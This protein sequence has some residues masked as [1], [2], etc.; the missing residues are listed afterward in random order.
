MLDMRVVRELLHVAQSGALNSG[1]SGLGIDGQINN[2]DVDNVRV[3]AGQ[4]R[5]QEH[6]VTRS[7]EAGYDARA[8]Q[9]IWDKRQDPRHGLLRAE[10]AELLA[11]RLGPPPHQLLHDLDPPRAHLSHHELALDASIVE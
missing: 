6:L 8:E 10:L 5:D 1:D 7:L 3:C 9:Q 4:V 11:H 2:E